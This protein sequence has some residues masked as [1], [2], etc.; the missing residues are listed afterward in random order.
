MIKEVVIIIGGNYNLIKSKE[1]FVEEYLEKFTQ[2]TGVRFED[3]SMYN[4]YETLARVVSD[5]IN[6]CWADTKV[7]LKQNMNKQVYYFS[8]EFLIGK[9]L[10]RYLTNLGLEQIVE[11]GLE[12]LDISLTELEEYEAEP[13]LGNGGLGRLAACYLES[14]AFLGISGNGNGIRYKHGLFEQKIINGYQVE[15]PDNWLNKPYLWEQKKPNSDVIVK[16]GGTVDVKNVDGRLAFQLQNYKPVKAVPYDIPIVSYNDVNG[17]NYLR[18]WSAEPIEQFDL[19]KFNEGNFIEAVKYKSAV[20]ALSQVLYPSDSTYEGRVLRLQQ[21]YFFVSAGIQSIVRSHKKELNK[22]LKELYKKISIHI[23]DTHPALCIPELM[24]VLIDEE[25]FSWDEAWEN[26]V[27]TMSYTNHTILPEALE[28]WPV[29]MIKQ[30]LPR[31]YM[32]IEEINNRFMNSLSENIYDENLAI[33]KN[34]NVYM[35]NL[36]VV[37]SSSVNGVAKIHS[38]ILKHEVMKD[39]YKVYPEKFNNKTNGV[40]HRRFLL[41]SNKPLSNLITDTIGDKWIEKPMEMVNL[42]NHQYNPSF[43]QDIFNVKHINKQR[44]A[45]HIKD[46]YKIEIDTNSIFDIHVKRI[47]AYKR[48]LLNVFHIMNLYNQI[49]ENPNTQMQPRTFIFAGKAAPSYYYAKKIIKLINSLANKINNDSIINNKI[50]IVFLENF[51]VSLAELIYPAADVSEQI[52]TASKEA[53]GTGNMKFMMNGAVT[54]GTLDGANVEILDEV[55]KDNMFIF[56]LTAQQVISYYKNNE[57][58]AYEMYKKDTRI[59]LILEQLVNGFLENDKGEFRDIYDSMLM[60][61]DEYFILKD[62]ASYV[63]TQHQLN[64]KY[65]N[66]DQWT[67]MCIN[68]I[69]HSGY[70]SSDRAVSEYAQDIWKI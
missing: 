38:E 50:K 67:N 69:A 8:I 26:T 29:N 21:Q 54:I 43:K 27:K 45:D 5:T 39:L 51:N 2:V 49:K 46:K 66:R 23:N 33:I 16:F 57:Y 3:G 6:E 44:L 68:N 32:I 28:K 40:T 25:G 52:S 24:R 70:F 17:V 20:E 56:G 41:N 36:A 37:G 10:R 48:Q 42:L 61:N 63:D 9:L 19:K 14:M 35:A 15:L 1:E 60:Y 62:F 55:G 58:R 47:H 13:G 53:S 64:Q 65:I 31:I 18:L 12:Q 22:N 4:K 7:K 11:E 34:D 59:Q 30:L